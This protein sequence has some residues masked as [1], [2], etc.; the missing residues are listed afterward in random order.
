MTHPIIA[1]RIAHVWERRAE[2]DLSS[3][4]STSSHLPRSCKY[5]SGNSGEHERN[6]EAEIHVG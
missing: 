5:K 6:A 2:N 1:E 3:R 4:S